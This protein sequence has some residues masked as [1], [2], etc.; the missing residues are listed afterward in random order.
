[1]NPSQPP[2]NANSY[3][4]AREFL[5]RGKL[6]DEQ[7]WHVHR[8]Q[9]ILEALRDV[10]PPDVAPGRLVELGCGAGTVTTYLNAHGYRVDY[11]DV[12]D[13]ALRVARSRAEA[14][15]GERVRDLRFL[16]L[17]VCHD[18]LP[19][20]YAGALLF[21]VLEHLPDDEAAL[22]RVQ[23]ALAPRDGG[24][25]LFT[26]PA[27]PM[28]WSPWDDVEKHKRRYTLASARRLAETTG[29]E[30]LR[31][32]YFF[33]P[34]FFAAGAVKML[35]TARDVVKPAPPPTSYEELT[36]AVSTPALN[37]ALLRVLALEKAWL[38]Q[39][40]LPLGTSL[41]CVARRAS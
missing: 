16:R 32:T 36:E 12:H 6:E 29:F 41:L 14:Q 20:G 22:R 7:Y 31:L 13:E 26:V 25:L 8:R 9:V 15:L 4:D 24:L 3:F 28:L 23:A 2:S 35:R 11:A 27:F 40:D 34:L 38:G 5:T 1:V 33:F 21:D 37:T 39:R 18:D 10:M 30:V 17:D 19:K